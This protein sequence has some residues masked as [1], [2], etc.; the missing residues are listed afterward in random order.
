MADP[1]WGQKAAKSNNTTGVKQITAK[2]LNAK[3]DELD[4]NK[5]G[6]IGPREYPRPVIFGRVDTNKDGFISREEAEAA[7]ESRPP[8]FVGPVKRYPIKRCSNA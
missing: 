2:Q 8:R 3:F 5:D 7:F 1:K 6:K 4:K